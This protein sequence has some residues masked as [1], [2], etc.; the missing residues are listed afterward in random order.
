MNADR[1]GFVTGGTW[2]VDHNMTIEAW[3]EE[4]SATRIL[5]T[6][7][8][9]GGSACNFAVDMRRL[10]PEIDVATIGLLGDD[11]DGRL[12]RG[13]ARDHGIDDALLTEVEGA[14]THRTWAFT[15]RR[16]GRRTHLF[17]ADASDR[18]SPEHFTFEGM[19]ARTLHLGLPGTHARLDAPWGDHASGWVAVL[20]AARRAGLETNLEV[21]S[22]GADEIRRLVRPCLPQLDTLVVN[23]VEIGALAGIG[24]VE[25]GTTDLAAVGEALRMV[26]ALGP[27]RLVVV[28]FPEGAIAMARDGGRRFQPSVAMPPEAVVGTN[29]A[30]DAFA[31]GL[32]CAIHRREELGRALALAHAAA[33]ASLRA[34]G[35]YDAVCSAEECL[36][37]A[38]LH[39]WREVASDR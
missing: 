23:D 34:T 36:R 26:M 8:R 10:A 38:A 13:V 19:R 7:S 5:G 20:D 15:A 33:A 6:E 9:G 16:N 24:T 12:L 39:G 18:L 11:A 3:P 28:H 30:G 1:H 35:T 17:E 25:A 32:F 14:T 29:G 21:M 31:A 22:V 37:L 27:M 4:E 2:C